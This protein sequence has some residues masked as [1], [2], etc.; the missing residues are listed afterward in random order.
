MSYTVMQMLGST[1]TTRSDAYSGK[2]CYR[3]T[4]MQTFLESIPLVKNK[5]LETLVDIAEAF[6]TVA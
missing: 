4:P 5:M 3:K 1:N 2:Y 6:D